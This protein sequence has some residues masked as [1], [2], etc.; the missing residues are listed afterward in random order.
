MKRDDLISNL[1]KASL[2]YD[3][4]LTEDP[5]EKE[6]TMTLVNEYLEPWA[7]QRAHLYIIKFRLDRG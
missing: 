2:L 4:T 5:E 6:I 7:I 1:L 3:Y